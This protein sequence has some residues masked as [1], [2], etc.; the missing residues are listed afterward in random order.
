MAAP[1][2]SPTVARMAASKAAGLAGNLA[3]LTVASTAA[4]WEIQMADLKVV[5]T[6]VSSVSDLVD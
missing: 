6:V 1:M 5:M 4:H 3:G 2:E